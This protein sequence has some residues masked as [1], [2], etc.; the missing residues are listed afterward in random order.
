LPRKKREKRTWTEPASLVPIIAAVISAIVGPT[1][2]YFYLV[3][4]STPPTVPTEEPIPD[5]PTPNSTPDTPAI[6]LVENNAL[7]VRTDKESYGFG[8]RVQV[9]GTADQTTRG[10]TVRLDVY[11]PE[12]IFSSYVFDPSNISTILA[13]DKPQSNI[14]VS[15]DEDGT[16]S[17]SFPLSVI[18]PEEGVKGNY[19][20]DAT[21]EGL[22]KNATFTVR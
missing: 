3:N 20:V 16:F 19:T 7:S 21:Y 17:Y 12:G 5:T 4:P 2:A 8:D 22:T 15:P 11:N 9:S 1:F 14:L 10:K 6:P 18:S 13:P